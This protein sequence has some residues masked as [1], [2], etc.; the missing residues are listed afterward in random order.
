VSGCYNS[1]SRASRLFP[2]PGGRGM[3][4]RLAAH[5]WSRYNNVITGH[6][7]TRF[8]GERGEA[9]CRGRCCYNN[10][11]TGYPR[12]PDF[13]G[14]RVKHW[15]RGVSAARKSQRVVREVLGMRTVY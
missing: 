2:A 9:G 10:V 11:I 13:W 8:C 12:R 15:C 6:E 14:G 5:G 4:R 7:R 1:L 3:R